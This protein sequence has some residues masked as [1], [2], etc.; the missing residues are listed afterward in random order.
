MTFKTKRKEMKLSQ[1]EVADALG[2]H[3]VTYGCYELGKRH[4]KPDMLKKMARFFGCSIDELLE[5]DSNDDK[6]RT[7]RKAGQT[8]RRRRNN[9]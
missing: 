9:L 6:K 7:R 3:Q 5:D 8:A 4:P 2:I 1:Q